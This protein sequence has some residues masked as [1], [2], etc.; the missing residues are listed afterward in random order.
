MKDNSNNNDDENGNDNQ[1]NGG[2]G[3]KEM[4]IWIQS[5]Q[6]EIIIMINE[7]REGGNIKDIMMKIFGCSYYCIKSISSLIVTFI[8]FTTRMIIQLFSYLSK[9]KGRR[10]N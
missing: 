7:C 8:L 4:V 5:L 6:T 10:Q 1:N 9:L 2:G 3:I